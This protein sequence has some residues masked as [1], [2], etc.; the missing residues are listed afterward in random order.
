M[1]RFTLFGMIARVIV[2]ALLLAVL[3]I[4]SIGQA[5]EATQPQMQPRGEYLS[6]DGALVARV[7][8]VGESG[9]DWAE[10][11][12]EIRTRS[13]RLLR[14]VSFESADTEHGEGVEHAAWTP[15]SKFFVFNTSSS[16]GHMPWHGP[17]YFYSTRENRFRRLDD[18]IG[19]GPCLAF[20]VAAPDVVRINAYDPIVDATRGYDTYRPVRVRFGRLQVGGH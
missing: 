14:F 20:S 19:P 17:A 7:L 1:W 18:Y 10:S 3:S 16:G 8:P 4:A 11:R 9:R 5:R 13:G 12:I 15:D 2:L 6:P